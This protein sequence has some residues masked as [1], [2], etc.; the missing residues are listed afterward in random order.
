VVTNPPAAAPAEPNKGRSPNEDDMKALL[1]SRQEKLTAAEQRAIAAEARLQ[2]LEQTV[3]GR[4]QPAS[5]PLTQG[6]QVLSND[7]QFGDERAQATLEVGKLAARA[8]LNT[9]LTKAMVKGRVNADDWDEVEALIVQSGYRMTVEQAKE[10]AKGTMSK[11]VDEKDKLAK[12]LA[13][14]KK[15]LE[16]ERTRV[17]VPN[18]GTVPAAVPVEGGSIPKSTYEAVLKQGG[19]EARKLK[20]RINSAKSAE[21]HLDIDWTQ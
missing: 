3:M 6:F 1:A 17:R 19:D 21:G 8:E 9:N 4:F 20:A 2:Q 7:A 10:R 15:Q 13:D 5:D 18:M 14:T 12:E 11:V 16:L